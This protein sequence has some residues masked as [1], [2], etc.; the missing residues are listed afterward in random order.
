[1]RIALFNH[2]D[3]VTSG[4]AAL[5]QCGATDITLVQVRER[6]VDLVL[7]DPANDPEG[8]PT[9]LTRLLA[10]PLVRRVAVLTSSFEPWRAGEFFAR[11]YAGY[12]SAALP[13]RQLLDAFNAIH[14]GERV[15]APADNPRH[16]S[17][18][19][20]AHGLT[21][22]ESDVLIL[23]ASGLSNKDIAA[24]LHLSPNSVKSYIRHAYGTLGVDS[25]TKA[26][27]WA[28]THGLH[29][30]A[31]ESSDIGRQSGGR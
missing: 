27:L 21:E 15:L 4:V 10:D 25:R 18:P 19:G 12:V 29:T 1:M 8:E 9:H 30:P 13:R 31:D 20:Q 6:P 2:D 5:V 26:V 17:W 16:E 28:L 3:V 24:Q 23:I 11:G 22:R 7:V 14:N